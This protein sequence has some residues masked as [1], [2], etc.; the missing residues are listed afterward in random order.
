MLNSESQAN[1][2]CLDAFYGTLLLFKLVE[3]F[4]THYSTVIIKNITHIPIMLV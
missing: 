4:K 1:S 3:S 2:S